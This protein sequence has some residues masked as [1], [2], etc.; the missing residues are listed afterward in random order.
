VGRNKELITCDKLEAG[1]VTVPLNVTVSSEDH[2]SAGNK[3][4]RNIAASTRHQHIPLYLTSTP[5][6]QPFH[7]T[8][9]PNVLA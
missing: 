2:C 6:K 4:R 7:V 8:L 1:A 3:R 9:N 5:G